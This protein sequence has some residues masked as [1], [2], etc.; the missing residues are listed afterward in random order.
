MIKITSE[1]AEGVTTVLGV[2]VGT[3]ATDDA[4]CRQVIAD[5]CPVRCRLP[6]FEVERY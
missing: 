2:A 1:I 5:R 4:Q 3:G 6:A